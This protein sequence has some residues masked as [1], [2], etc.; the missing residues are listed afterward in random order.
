MSGQPPQSNAAHAPEPAS[1]R[2]SS[3]PPSN[4]ST[5]LVSK[6][7]CAA[8]D[9]GELVSRFV[10]E[11]GA[12]RAHL[13]FVDRLARA[14]ERPRTHQSADARLAATGSCGILGSGNSGTKGVW[15]GEGPV[16]ALIDAAEA[17]TTLELV[18]DRDARWREQLASMPEELAVVAAWIRDETRGE[19]PTQQRADD[20]PGYVLE[21]PAQ[22]KRLARR[23]TGLSLAEIVGLSTA[24]ASQRA[25]WEAKL[26]AGDSVPARDGMRERGDF[27]LARCARAWFGER[28]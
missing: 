12:W 17:S 28:A 8:S 9:R 14:I 7:A 21:Y 13:D 2:S 26:M 3:G 25:R 1:A 4:G 24:E 16:D 18:A 11:L 20:P 27:L 6:G 19:A 23:I 22:G 10:A 15:C 5:V